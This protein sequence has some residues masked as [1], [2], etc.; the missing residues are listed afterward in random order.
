MALTE[1]LNKQYAQ[2][3]SDSI[4]ISSL[5]QEIITTQIPQSSD[6]GQ[7]AIDTGS[8]QVIDTF[9]LFFK[10]RPTDV[11]RIQDLY[12]IE[13]TLDNINFVLSYNP[14]KNITG[15]LFFKDI[16][17]NEKPLRVS[18]RAIILEPQNSNIINTFTADP[19]AYIQEVDPFTYQ[20]YLQLQ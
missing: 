6:Q 9:S 11:K 4:T 12:Y 1:Y 17:I 18:K 3:I 19:L 15:P 14:Q 16:I 13:F 5:I 10:T 7:I 2:T 8:I 20:T